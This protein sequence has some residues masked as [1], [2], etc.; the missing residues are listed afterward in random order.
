MQKSDRLALIIR[1]I[2]WDKAK[3]LSTRY[4]IVC[5]V[6]FPVALNSHKFTLRQTALR[7]PIKSSRHSRNSAAFRRGN[8]RNTNWCFSS[9]NNQLELHETIV[10]SLYATPTLHYVTNSRILS[11][12]VL[13]FDRRSWTIYFYE[14]FVEY[15]KKILS[16]S[17]CK[18]ASLNT[19]VYIQLVAFTIVK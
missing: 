9:L 5:D 17:K 16:K 14:A 13:F 6:P 11:H 19:S 1:K 2:C 10:A 15:K 7:D 3:F 4:S 8:A 18:Y 12:Y